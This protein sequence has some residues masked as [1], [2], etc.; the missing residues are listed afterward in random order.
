MTV[1]II[2]A[3]GLIA[4]VLWALIVSVEWYR[5]NGRA[6]N[7]RKA[8]SDYQPYARTMAGHLKPFKGHERAHAK[9]AVAEYRER[10][11]LEAI[12]GSLRDRRN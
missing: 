10:Q 3:V 9:D 8:P 6:K 4:F 1:V 11:R 5:S 12:S 2:G 7:V